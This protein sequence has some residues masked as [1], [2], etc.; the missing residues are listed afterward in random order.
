MIVGAGP[1]AA[2]AFGEVVLDD[3]GAATKEVC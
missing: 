1:R 2:R 3:V